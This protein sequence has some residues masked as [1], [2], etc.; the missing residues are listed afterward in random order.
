MS[1]EQRPQANPESHGDA[2]ATV[3]AA[4]EEWADRELAAYPDKRSA[5]VD[6]AAR[7]LEAGASPQGAAVAARLSA[8]A[9]V[10]PGEARA[11]WD[12][13]QGLERVVVELDA[14]RPSG[15]LTTAGLAQLHL[16]FQARCEALRNLY[17]AAMSTLPAA[18]PPVGAAMHDQP[19]PG[20]SMREF[21]A[22]NSIL[23]ISIAGAFLLIVAT[24][25]FEIYGS[26]G[27][28]GQ[29][30]FTGVLV[31]NLVFGVAG[32]L[33]LSRSRLRLVGQTYIAIFALMA[34]LTVAAAYV[35]LTLGERGISQELAVGMGG[36]GCSILYAILATR[37][38]SRGYAALSMVA[39]PVG[40]VGLVMWGHAGIWIGPWLAPLVLVYIAIAF[41][42]RESPPQMA[43]FAR[44][45]EPFIHGAAFLALAWSLRLAVPEWTS[46]YGSASTRPSF[47][48]ATTLALLTVAYSLYC[49]RSR[50]AWMLWAVW[51]GVSLTV[52]AANEP[53]AFGQ[54]GYAIELA[55]LAWA[56]AI[57]ARWMSGRSLR[58]FVRIG[59]AVQAAFPVLLSASPDGLQAFVLLAT[60]GVG[61]FLAFE[62]R[63]PVWL[64]LAAGIFSVD[65][66]WLAKSLLPPPPHPTAN[67]LIL[68]YSPLPVVYALVALAL[69][70]T[71]RRR[72]SWPLYA[73]AALI[74]LGV[75]ISAASQN[76]L[77]LAGRS[78]VVYAGLA[79]VVSSLDRFWPGLVAAMLAAAAAMLLLFGAAGTA[80]YWYPVGM[81]GLAILIY[82]AHRAWGTSDLARTHRFIALAIAGLTAAASFTVPDFWLK[83]GVGSVSALASL[84]GAAGLVFID[85]RIFSRPL[86]D[87]VAAAIASLGGF[88]IARYLGIDNLQASV[89]LPGVALIVLGVLAP[90]DKRRPASLAMCRGA[91]AGGAAALMGASAY[92]SVTEEAAA[93][94]TTIWVVEA[95]AS[96]LIGIWSRSRTL[97]LAGGAGLALGALRALFLIL[98]SVQ[99]YVVFGVIALFLL[100]AAG[101]LA[102]TRD[103]LSTARSAVTR[104][105]DEW[106]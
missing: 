97:V 29:V 90:Q 87:Y 18:S 68:T 39:L 25:L 38:G 24:L 88:W 105:W 100:V 33:C 23:I 6:A 65:W 91:I 52:L 9:S 13:L 28:G 3:R 69:R 89:A 10:P 66:F 16:H 83:A 70:L 67:T 106:T 30:R 40:W 92:Q 71:G 47:Q 4:W 8:G 95:V 11:L 76:D 21:F 41:P 101:V 19:P 49:L 98:Q 36:L 34:P 7:A 73:T 77:T 94:Y 51:A 59:A 74:A 104:S 53:L 103:R 27:F 58:T 85:G 62:D 57:G 102:A 93:S 80:T 35:F 61:L 31:L 82:S 81:T 72:W 86:L 37:L 75:S 1:N 96:L 43:L 5:A 99:V 50:R 42:V 17:I 22:D 48:L 78:L 14:I 55:I 20:P 2:A 26:T 45:G 54:R 12:E 64:L 44:L 46:R 84:I 32:Y 56:Y 79:Y 63:R 60:A 15:D